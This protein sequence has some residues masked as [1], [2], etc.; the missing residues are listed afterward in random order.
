MYI[1]F[2]N[3]IF[4]ETP[5]DA[6][7]RDGE[8]GKGIHLHLHACLLQNHLQHLKNSSY[9][10]HEV[11]NCLD[12]FMHEYSKLDPLDNILH[13]NTISVRINLTHIE[14]KEHVTLTDQ[15]LKIPGR[16]LIIF[17]VLT[18]SDRQLC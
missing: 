2:L 9:I 6:R 14:C 1:I 13:S 18:E 17:D 4:S 16:H 10:D 7:G 11:K 12:L 5:I 3:T 15:V 8:N